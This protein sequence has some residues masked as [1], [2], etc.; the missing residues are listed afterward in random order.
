MTELLPWIIIRVQDS[1]SSAGAGKSIEGRQL[2]GYEDSFGGATD[3][4]QM[5]KK[6]ILGVMDT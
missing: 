2:A 5:T 6:P 1:G 3:I 4:L